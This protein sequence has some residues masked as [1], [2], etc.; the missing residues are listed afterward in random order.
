MN[1]KWQTIQTYRKSA[2][3]LSEKWN[4]VQ[5]SGRITD[6]QR[7]FSY[8]SKKNPIVVELGCGNGRDAKVIIKKTRNYLGIDISP[9]LIKIAKKNVPQVKFVVSDIEK[10]N[11]PNNIDIIFSFASLLHFNKATIK[12]IM[13]KIYKKLNDKGILY[14]SLKYGK[15]H[16]KTVKDRYGM[17]TYYF[18]QP[19]DIKDL[20]KNKYKIIYKE[21]QNLRGQEWLTVVLQKTGI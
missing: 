5:P 10:F 16:S 13:N 7:A 19:I 1:N 18:Y 15:Y 8:F 6:I 17:R 14:L 4:L 9:E 2:L 20:A 12:K 11:F 21:V 3:K